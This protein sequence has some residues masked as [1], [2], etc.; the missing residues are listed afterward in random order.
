MEYKCISVFALPGIDHRLYLPATLVMALISCFNGR[1]LF[2]QSVPGSPV[3]TVDHN[4]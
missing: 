4:A 2:F 1:N 3:L